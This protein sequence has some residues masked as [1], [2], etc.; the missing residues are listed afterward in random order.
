MTRLDADLIARALV[1]ACSVYGLDPLRVFEPEGRRVRCLAGAGLCAVCRAPKQR[2]AG[3]VRVSLAEI[4]PSRLAIL[5]LPPRV[6]DALAETLV[7]GGCV[8]PVVAA[9]TPA[10]RQTSPRPKPIPKA[11]RPKRQ[12]LGEG[13]A[14]TDRQRLV[15]DTL[16][17]LAN[18]DWTVTVSCLE[19][20]R[21][22]EIAAY[23]ARDHIWSLRRKGCVELIH[24]GDRGVPATY[25]IC[26]AYRP[27][28]RPVRPAPEPPKARH[29]V[30]KAPAARPPERDPAPR[31]GR[32]FIPAP[33]PMP[34][35]GSLPDLGANT[36]DNAR[37]VAF[38][39]RGPGCCCWPIEA[40]LAP[41]TAQMLVCG[42]PSDGEGPYCRSHADRAYRGAPAPRSGSGGPSPRRA[43]SFAAERSPSSL[44]EV[45]A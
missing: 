28:Q 29:I 16:I 3:S 21:I 41:S 39:D 19:V 23:T 4:T 34:E 7:K 2:I 40:T 8:A 35:D 22:A 43:P 13:S 5:G 17:S 44:D 25:R 26:E 14:L 10:I 11:E 27:A 1:N 37:P 42:A 45:F 6:V 9:T 33:V 12:P 24:A 18:S 31:R 38:T 32:P 36:P 30:F 15:L 20:E